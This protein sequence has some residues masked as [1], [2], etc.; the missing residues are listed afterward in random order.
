[1]EEL[2]LVFQILQKTDLNKVSWDM[3][4]DVS[5]N[6]DGENPKRLNR[7]ILKYSEKNAWLNK[8]EDFNQKVF[9]SKVS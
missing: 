5:V 4:S 1:M 9:R 3:K 2:H 8:L 6:A 7:N